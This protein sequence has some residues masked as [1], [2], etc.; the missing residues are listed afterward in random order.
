MNC[1]TFVIDCLGDK[2]LLSLYAVERKNGDAGID[3]FCTEDC[4]VPAHS[5]GY[6]LNFKIICERR[7]GGS[8]YLYPRSS[9]SK[10]PLRLANSV[11]I[12]DAGYRGHIMA[13]VDNMSDSEYI[14]KRG[15]RLFQI[16]MPD[17]RTP[18]VIF[19]HVSTDTE[20][21]SGGFGSTGR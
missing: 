10:T 6:T 11:G 12:I 18:T 17:L 20:R 13:K 7:P 3:L 14:I 16:C 5:F 1:D 8:Y 19:D 4:C 15:D 2:E 9:I 21:G